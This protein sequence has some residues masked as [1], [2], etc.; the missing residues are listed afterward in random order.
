MACYHP[1]SATAEELTLWTGWSAGPADG[2]QRL[3]EKLGA[4][5]LPAVTFLD[6]NTMHVGNTGASRRSPPPWAEAPCR[7]S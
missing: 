7:G 2:V 1:F 4:G 3:V 6:L 5:S